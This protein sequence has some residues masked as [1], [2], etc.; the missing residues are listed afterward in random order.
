MI[1][2]F[3]VFIPTSVVALLFSEALI[4]VGCYIA[5][6]YYFLPEYDPQIFLID[7]GGIWRI[8]L[9]M[10]VIVLGLYFND[11]YGT[12]RVRHRVELIQQLCMA[13]GVAFLSQA[14]ISYVNR[15]WTIPKALMIK[16]S[17]VVIVALFGWRM[18]FSA[19][20]WKAIGVQRV[21]FLGRSPIVFQ[22]AAHLFEHPELGFRPVGYLDEAA[23]EKDPES[24]LT[25]LGNTTDVVRVA[26]EQRPDHIVVGMSERRTRMPTYELLDLRFSGIRIDEIARLYEITFGR[27]C[28]RE[29]RPSQLIFTEDLAPRKRSL[30]LQSLYSKLLAL[31]ALIIAGPIMLLVAL[32]VR[33]TSS[34][35]ILYRQPRVGLRE[36]IFNVYKFRSMYQDAEARTGPVWATRN[37]PR[38]TPLGNWL[39]R[40]RLDELPQ[41][42]NVIAGEMSIVGPRPER[43]EFT[44][45]LSTKIPYY[46][47]RH[48]VM[49]G[50]TGWAQIN[51]KYGDTI[52]DTIMKLEYD[53]YYIK[54]ASVWLDFFIMFQT[55]KTMLLVRGSQ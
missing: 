33:L 21:L 44:Q 40:L 30:R 22:V 8:V 5:L 39:R 52:E 10:L 1:R 50:I 23:F 20:I 25:C 37:D 54:H 16:G 49:P 41:L 34:G 55:A 3:K 6:F 28:T 43:P 36:Q 51:Y 47:Q 45:M 27:V 11:L 38:V 29:I 53:L 24:K 15:D 18:L 7:E 2:L 19:T 46:R 17:T 4:I 26:G 14:L 42:F 9:V 48:C 35:P 31:I 13:I 12:I 32:A